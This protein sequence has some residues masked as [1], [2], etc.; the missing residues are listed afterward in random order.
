MVEGAPIGGGV[1]APSSCPSPLAQCALR[2]RPPKAGAGCANRARRDLCGGRPVTGGPI[3][4]PP[5]APITTD[6][7]A[8][9]SCRAMFYVPL[10]PIVVTPSEGRCF[11]SS[12][13]AAPMPQCQKPNSTSDT[14]TARAGMMIVQLTAVSKYVHG[15]G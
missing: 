12:F 15:A 6:F 8:C 13:D 10:P 2:R 5:N 9:L 7:V 4:I 14:M 11:G 1:V 3:A